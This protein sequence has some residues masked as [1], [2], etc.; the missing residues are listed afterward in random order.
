MRALKVKQLSDVSGVSV[1]TLHHYDK[2]GLLKPL[3]RSEKGYRLYGEK[4]LLRLQQILFYKEL[5]FPLSKIQEILEQDGFNIIGALE[6]QKQA[7]TEK[8]RRIDTL[9]DTL[10][11]TIHSICKENNMLSEN[12]I[13][14]GFSKKEQESHKN[15][16]IET[17]GVDSYQNSINK[18]RK[19]TKHQWADLQHEGENINRALAEAMNLSPDHP[20]VQNLIKRHYEYIEKHM[21]LTKNIYSEL[22]KMYEQDERFYAYYEKYAPQLA[23]FLNK[24]IQMYC[25]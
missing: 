8:K 2:I 4:E 9:L 10:D 14:A 19:M 24:A 6:F 17:Y 13:F 7:L 23:P 5:E 11:Y 22:G 1:K 15:E 21:E 16:V 12:E 3:E 18:I 20:N 25:S